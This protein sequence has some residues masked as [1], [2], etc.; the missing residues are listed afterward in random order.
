MGIIFGVWL[1]E[2]LE[3][4]SPSAEEIGPD[5]PCTHRWTNAKTLPAERC[6]NCNQLRLAQP[7]PW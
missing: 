2:P 6:L 3:A 7:G 4:K 5:S 1:A